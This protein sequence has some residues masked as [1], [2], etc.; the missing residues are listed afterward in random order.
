MIYSDSNKRACEE[1]IFKQLIGPILI[2][3]FVYSLSWVILSKIENASSILHLHHAFLAAVFSFWFSNWD[4]ISAIVWH[5][6]NIGIWVEGWNIYGTEEIYIFME[7]KDGKPLSLLSSISIII[8][9]REIQ[10]STNALKL[11]MSDMDVDVD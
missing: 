1:N 8:F 11:H 10:V 6:I 2:T 9:L 5:A 4:N 7:S 3:L